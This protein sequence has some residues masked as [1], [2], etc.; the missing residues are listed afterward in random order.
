MKI[1]A[2]LFARKNPLKQKSNAKMD[3][4]LLISAGVISAG[5]IMGAI[6]YGFNSQIFSS[7]L[8]SYFFEFSYNF[9]NKTYLEI[10][11][12]LFLSNLLYF[13]IMVVMGTSAV[14]SYFVLLPTLCKSLGLGALVCYLYMSFGLLGFEYCMLVLFPGKILFLLVMLLLTQIC[15]K[16][17]SEIKA[18]LDATS[19][20]KVQIKTFF[21]SVTVIFMILVA[22]SMVDSVMIL[23]FASLFEF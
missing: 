16:M 13:C 7:E 12:G 1:K 19:R 5:L 2:V 21:F 9:S 3:K 14:G 20:E 11:S 18:Q 17:S 22:C 4:I 10:F 6:S 23:L 15:F 8:W